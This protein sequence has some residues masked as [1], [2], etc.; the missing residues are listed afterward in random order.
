MFKICNKNTIATNVFVVSNRHVDMYL[1]G[2]CLLST[3]K[4]KFF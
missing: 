2:I 4:A 3:V 1:S